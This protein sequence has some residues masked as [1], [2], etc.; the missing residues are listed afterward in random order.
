MSTQGERLR[1]E[2]FAFERLAS[3]RCRAKV[4]L[5]WAD[6]RQFMGEA[7]GVISQAGELRCCAQATDTEKTKPAKD[8]FRSLR[9]SWSVPK[10]NKTVFSQALICIS[11]QLLS[12]Q[13]WIE[14][15]IGESTFGLLPELAFCLRCLLGFFSVSCSERRPKW[16]RSFQISLA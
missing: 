5:T 13:A 16:T 4:V 14:I 7:E 2:D 15:A 6:G 11:L 1:F 3:G 10:D 8:K 12:N 9:I